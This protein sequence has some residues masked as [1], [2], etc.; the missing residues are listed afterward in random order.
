MQRYQ[1]KTIN[2]LSNFLTQVN[3]YLCSKNT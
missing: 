1:L 3:F 2:Q